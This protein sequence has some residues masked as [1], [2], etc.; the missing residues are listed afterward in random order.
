MGGWEGL[1]WG[2]GRVLCGGLGGSDV[3]GWEGLIWGAG[4]V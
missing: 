1:M 4:R 2:A 3:G